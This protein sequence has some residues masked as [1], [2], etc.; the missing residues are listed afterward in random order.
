MRSK[1]KIHSYLFAIMGL[2]L[3]LSLSCN[4]KNDEAD[5]PPSGTVKDADGNVYHTVTIGTQVWMVE[6]LKTTKYNDGTPIPHVVSDEDWDRL[7]TPGYCWY[8]NDTTYKNT[9]GALYNW[10]AVNTGKLAP[11]GWHVATDQEWTT[12][13]NYL[14][15]ETVAGGKMKSTGTTLWKS[16]NQGATNTIGFTAVPG[17]FRSGGGGQFGAKGESGIWWSSS[18]NGADDAWDWHVHWY[19]IEVGRTDLN[20]RHA[21][22]VRCVRN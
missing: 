3:L 2:L 15:G 20:Q 19:D 4:K 12:L 22:S 9:Y 13:T 18:A 7:L 21:F 14:G 10:F 5:P 16:P 11:T 6:N 1:T 8:N 17:G